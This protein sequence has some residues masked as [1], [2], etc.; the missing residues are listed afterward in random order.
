MLALLGYLAFQTMRDTRE[1]LARTQLVA[2]CGSTEFDADSWCLP[3]DTLLG[4][5]EIPTGLFTMGSDLNH[6]AAADGDETPPHEVML[7][8]YYIGRYEVTVAQFQAFVGATA[9]AYEGSGLQEVPDRPMTEVSWLDAMAYT[10]WLDEALRREAPSALQAIL[11]NGFGVTLPSEAEWEKA[12][13]GGD[14]RIYPWGDDL[15][16]DDGQ[17]RANFRSS[18]TTS[19]GSFPCPACAFGLADMAGNVWEWTRSLYEPYL[20][21]P[22]DGREARSSSAPRVVRGGSFLDTENGVRAASRGRF[23]PENRFYG[24]GFRVVVSPFLSDSDR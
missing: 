12:A 11:N 4:F 7:P 5:V 24:I 1:Q 16:P 8:M 9:Y 2:V 19:V 23:A 6:D 10:E 3:S 15:V 18:T 17:P 22:R 21:D 20:Y 13:R 14:D